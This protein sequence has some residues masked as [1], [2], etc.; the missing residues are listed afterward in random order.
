MIQLCCKSYLPYG[1]PRK[2]TPL[3][4][5]NKKGDKMKKTILFSPVG[6]TDPIRY[7]KDGA[8]LNIIRNYAPDTVYLYMSKEIL[9][10]H[11]EDNR[12]L[13]SIGELAGLLGKKIDVHIIERPE[14]ED[15]QL[16]DSFIADFTGILNK[17]HGDYPDD[18]IILN[19]SSGTPAMKSSLQ[20]LSLTLDFDMLPVQ[21]STPQKKSNP[22]ID[23]EKNASPQELWELNESNS[24][25]D[26]RCITSQTENL[27]AEFKKQSLIKLIR[28]Y[29]YSAALELAED[30]NVP[31]KFIELLDAANNRLKLNYRKTT[32]VFEKYGFNICLCDD[33]ELEAAAEYILLLQIK[34]KKQEYADFIRAITPVI[35]ELF[36]IYLK[37]KCDVNVWDYTDK[38]K[39]WDMNK[40]NSD[41]NGVKILTHLNKFY[42][43]RLKMCHVYSDAACELICQMSGDINAQKAANVLRDE[44][45]KKIRNNAAHEIVSITEEKIQK[46]T[47]HSSEEIIKYLLDMLKLCGMNI[48][49][50]FSLAYDEMNDII[51]GEI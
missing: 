46:D 36:V 44:V 37:N 41:D 43:G 35:L 48:S 4:D 30:M 40:L 33:K 24:E 31:Q 14:L 12:Y 5:K 45:E 7:F 42:N 28:S 22:R 29:D 8:M 23:D 51:I 1:L 32:K 47:G 34:I 13:Y 49:R 50:K 26:N 18:K 25:E 9:H 17:L 16:F 3:G 21:V 39:K 15:V 10:H 27:L 38:N 11:R 2:I 20:I 19:V 6:M